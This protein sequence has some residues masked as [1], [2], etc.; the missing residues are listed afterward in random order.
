MDNLINTEKNLPRIDLKDQPTLVCEVCDSKYFKEVVMVKKVS[1]LL[2]G[3]MEDT[4]V[5]FPTY[6]CDDCGHVNKD[7]E[8]F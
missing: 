4:I 6:R 5:P 2:T 8:L 3:S 1:K 7:F